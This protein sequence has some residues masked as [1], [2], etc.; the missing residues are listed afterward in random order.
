MSKTFLSAE[1]RRLILANYEVDSN[2][3]SFKIAGASAF[4]EAFVQ[5][6]PKLLE[7][8]NA[9]EI[10]VP[11]ELMGD[12][13]TDLQSRR[14]I[15][16]GVDSKG[17]YQII[18]AKVPLA[19]L[20]RYITALRSMTQGKASFTSAFAEYSPVPYEVQ[21]KLMNAHSTQEELVPG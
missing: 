20:D 9:M 1:W 2:D 21:K 6:D 4:K 19:E 5:A 3:I 10:L 13:M 15:I 8:I 14:A 17:K 11:E 18:S 12:V 7:P 16:T